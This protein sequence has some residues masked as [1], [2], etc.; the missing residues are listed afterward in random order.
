[1]EM[2][3]I[4][5][6]SSTEAGG[7]GKRRVQ[8]GGGGSENFYWNTQGEPLWTREAWSPKP[9]KGLAICR[10]KAVP[11]FLSYLF[12]LLYVKYKNSI[13]K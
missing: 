7:E 8:L 12:T 9:C 10:A 5:T 2:I 11:S 4:V 1:M 3:Y 6:L 13:Q